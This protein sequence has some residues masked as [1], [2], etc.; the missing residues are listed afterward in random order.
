MRLFL[1]LRQDFD[2][3]DDSYD[4]PSYVD[5]G[6][7]HDLIP[8]YL[9]DVVLY[10]QALDFVSWALDLKTIFMADSIFEYLDSF[11]NMVFFQFLLVLHLLKLTQIL[12]VHA[13]LLNII[14]TC[15]LL[16]TYSSA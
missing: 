15:L 9:R 3:I 11:R 4:F 12:I 16:N 2:S 1:L 13:F 14:K 7:L 5:L 6:D 10:L 8:I